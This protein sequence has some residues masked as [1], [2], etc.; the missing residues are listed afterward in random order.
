MF[1]VG[2]PDPTPKC[3]TGRNYW[4]DSKPT[5]INELPIRAANHLASLYSWLAKRQ[6][7]TKRYIQAEVKWTAAIDVIAMLGIVKDRHEVLMAV[8]SSWRKQSES[9]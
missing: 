7:R 3:E 5:D 9:I 2:D 1:K 8:N 6:P 4:A